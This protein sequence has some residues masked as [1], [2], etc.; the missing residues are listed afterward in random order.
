MSY[1]T[2]PSR[3]PSNY[4]NKSSSSSSSSYMYQ[5][6]HTSRYDSYQS[7]DDT[8]FPASDPYGSR[9]P[10]A[11]TN[12]SSSSANNMMFNPTCSY[13]NNSEA[14][15]MDSR[16][17]KQQAPPPGHI[18]DPYDQP[19]SRNYR[20]SSRS[21]SGSNRSPVSSYNY[22]RGS[23]KKMKK[24]DDSLNQSKSNNSSSKLDKSD[25]YEA[26]NANNQAESMYGNGNEQTVANSQLNG[27]NNLK[28]NNEDGLSSSESNKKS[29]ENQSDGTRGEQQPSDVGVKSESDNKNQSEQN[30]SQSA[31]SHVNIVLNTNHWCSVNHEDISKYYRPELAYKLHSCLGVNE[32]SWIFL[33]FFMRK[34]KSNGNFTFF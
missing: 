7:I 31:G 24:S 12:P 22:G 23:Y 8:K 33:I 26:S 30:T 19:S 5:R 20:N 16:Y 9:A 25:Y 2:S 15:Y 28:L 34:L 27:I 1:R 13:M 3:Y 29:K 6:H 11:Q 17:S 21:S 18:V 14:E 10:P 4:D 32:V